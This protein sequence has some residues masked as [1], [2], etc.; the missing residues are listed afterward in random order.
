[1]D[2]TRLI[3]LLVIHPEKTKLNSETTIYCSPDSGKFLRHPVYEE[4]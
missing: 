4:S 1:M 3:T 2:F